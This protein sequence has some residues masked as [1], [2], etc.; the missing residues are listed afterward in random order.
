MSK[1]AQAKSPQSHLTPWYPGDTKPVRVGVYERDWGADH[2]LVK[3]GFSYFDGLHWCAGC[4]TPQYAAR[5][6]RVQGHSDHQTLPWRGLA[7]DPA[8]APPL[9]RHPTRYRSPLLSK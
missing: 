7:F 8:P 3:F 4:T 6:G 2:A 9:G 5:E 1:T